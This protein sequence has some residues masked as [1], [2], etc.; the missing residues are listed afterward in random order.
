LTIYPGRVASPITY[1]NTGNSP[2][3]YANLSST[4]PSQATQIAAL[5]EKVRLLA[6]GVRIIPIQAATADQGVIVGSLLGAERAADAV[7]F[8][9]TVTGSAS[10]NYGFNEIGNYQGST[11]TPFRKGLTA[12]WRPQD[13]N[14]FVFQEAF[15]TDTTTSVSTV[16]GVPFIQVGISGVASGAQFIIEYIAHYEGYV[17]A[18]NAGVIAIDKSPATPFT[19]VIKGV[20]KLIPGNVTTRSGYD[21]GF[22]TLPEISMKPSSG[23]SKKGDSWT[24][25]QVLGGIKEG[26]EL[27]SS[28]YTAASA[29]GDALEEMMMFLL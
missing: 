20:D 4:N 17:L 19:D 12:V 15:L 26:A 7:L 14:S 29:F 25:P 18:G 13:P 27:A 1:S 10:A 22:N 9:V 21:G 2:Y 24:V 3:N 11:M 8:G 16:Q 5:Y 6:C 28:A 23:G